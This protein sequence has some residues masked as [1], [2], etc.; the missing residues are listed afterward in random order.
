MGASGDNMT[1]GAFL[2]RL[3]NISSLANFIKL[4]TERPYVVDGIR[5]LMLAGT[6]VDI[7]SLGVD[8]LVLVAIA[9]V[10]VFIC[11]ALYPR[12]VQ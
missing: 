12:I 2:G 8:T 9:C 6:T 10:L 5:M 3:L 7:A 1:R 4:F 11:A